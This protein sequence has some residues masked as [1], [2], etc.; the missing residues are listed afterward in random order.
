MSLAVAPNG[1]ALLALSDSSGVRIATGTA[2]DGLGT[3]RSLGAGKATGVS[4][5]LSASGAAAVAWMA[6]DEQGAAPAGVSDRPA[7]GDFGAAHAGV[8]VSDRPA[9]G[10]FGAA[11]ALAQPTSRLG[12]DDV[13]LLRLAAAA[14]G[15]MLAS[16]SVSVRAAELAAAP[17]LVAAQRRADGAWEPVV[18]LAGPCRQ[19]ID[20][21]PGFDAS[22]RPRVTM[23]DSGLISGGDYGFPSDTRVRVV[24]LGAGAAALGPPPR[25]TL[26]AARRQILRNDRV[27]L[28]VRCALPCDAR[29][30]GVV[31]GRSGAASGLFPAFH[32]LR[33][34]RLKAVVLKRGD[35][36][37]RTGHALDGD[38][39]TVRVKL[40][41]HAC[42]SA[43][44]L[45][46][47][48]RTIDVRVPR[49]AQRR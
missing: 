4:A 3:L 26:S 47:A 22:G 40:V 39:R 23:I 7:G 17:V 18:A 49:R 48:R 20:A 15:R 41:V 32:R 37:D 45:A 24:G 14:D 13:A 12:G 33:P 27:R 43:G 19:P 6:S 11:H 35:Y 29:I 34:G 30:F 36:F 8:I 21:F 28:R 31:R 42:D 16:W 44:R 38:G 5:A 2:R 25:V 10:D 9:G 1:E 46:R